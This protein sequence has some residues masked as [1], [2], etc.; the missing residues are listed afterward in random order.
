MNKKEKS[1]K[2]ETAVKIFT[3][4]AGFIAFIILF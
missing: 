1:Y 2:V 3:Y 4:S